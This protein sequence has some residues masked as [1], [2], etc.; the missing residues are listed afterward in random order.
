LNVSNPTNNTASIVSY[1]NN[2]SG[3][4]STNV[5]DAID[6]LAKTGGGVT[7]AVT[8]VL[9]GTSNI[10]YGTLNYDRYDYVG[11]APSNAPDWMKMIVNL[12][13]GVTSGKLTK[14]YIIANDL[15]EAG[16]GNNIGNGVNGVS[17]SVCKNDTSISNDTTELN[18]G[19]GKVVT[20]LIP[21]V[22][23]EDNVWVNGD[24]LK[25]K[26]DVKSNAENP[27]MSFVLLT[28]C[29]KL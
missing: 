15:N 19:S 11:D 22:S 27:L 24:A 23:D 20:D 25:L 17:L 8:E 12:P 7:T 26:L 28:F 13:P 3:L 1:E 10:W 9:S 4:S 18:T 16:T 6:E 2:E 21:L 14:A 5:Q 29:Q